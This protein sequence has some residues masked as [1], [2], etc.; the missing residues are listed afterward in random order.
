MNQNNKKFKV[1]LVYPDIPG[2]WVPPVTIG[3]FTSLLK[4]AGFEVDLFDATFY[5]ED[6]KSLE[7]E[8]RV[9]SGQVRK[10]SYENALGV[11]LKPNLVKGFLE[12]IDSSKP[13]LLMVSVVEGALKR[14]LDLLDAVK[15]R[16]I[17]HVVG[18]VFVTAVPEI[19]IA[20]PQI[21]TICVGEGENAVLKV[22]E[23][24][25]DGLSIDDVP[26]LWLKKEDGQIIKNPLG[27][28]VDINDILPDYSL[29]ENTR[30]YRPM[31]GK[32][33]RTIPLETSRG[34]PFT[35]AYCNSPMWTRLYRNNCQAVFVRRKRIDR[36]IEEMKYL[37]KEYKP[38]LL[39]IIDDCFLARPEGEFNE[40][41][42]QYREINLPFF[43]ITRIEYITEERVKLLKEINCYRI[44][45][46]IECGNEEF[47]RTKLKRFMA[48]E[49]L[50]KHMKILA[51]SGI[52]FSVNN[53]IGF[54]DETRDLIFD[55]IELNRQVSGY[56]TLTVSI[57]TPYHGT[58][59]RED[60]IKSGYLDAN[61]P[62]IHTRE[63]S[64]LRMPQL[65]AQ[66][67]DGLMRT[68]VMYV[69]FPKKWWPY[70]KIAE[71]FTEAGNRM[72]AKLSKMHSEIFLTGDQS[73][74]IKKEPDWD[75][76]EKRLSDGKQQ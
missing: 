49:K 45:V 40:F 14:T 58:E 44:S 37:V 28:L 73:N 6:E 26:N 35:C 64:L 43:I 63:S 33:L 18:G 9:E 66:Q 41:V 20:Y 29:F 60:A 10:F 67:I 76:L 54:P 39:Y 42:R 31:G 71:E 36:V 4:R 56:D 53:I 3:I 50:L 27:P 17:P 57:F 51:Q 70:I 32:V 55:T 13:D 59:L 21:K 23:R 16:N 62:V 2:Q 46:G 72:F 12:K 74:K 48:N 75:E 65:T 25:R 19:A 22:A 38:E 8:K 69:R 52:P 1:L 7:V 34:C 61:V 47:R 5:L 15:D 68:F 11:K 30:F 24:L